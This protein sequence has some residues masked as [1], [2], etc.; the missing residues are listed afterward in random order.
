MIYILNVFLSKKLL[1]KNFK[2]YLTP[3][4]KNKESAQFILLIPYNLYRYKMFM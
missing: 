4:Q 3:T 1:Y 2:I